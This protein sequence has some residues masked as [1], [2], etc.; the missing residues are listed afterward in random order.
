MTGYIFEW[1]LNLPSEKGCFVDYVLDFIVDPN[2]H[3]K[4]YIASG[5]IPDLLE[6]IAAD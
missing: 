2:G 6:D 1:G 4:R 5:S 3:L